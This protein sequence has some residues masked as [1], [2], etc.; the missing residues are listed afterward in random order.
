MITFNDLKEKYGNR[1]YLLLTVAIVTTSFTM[2]T[3]ATII[4]VAVPS[5]MGTFG[6]GQDKA[7]LMATSFYVAMTASQLSCAFLIKVFGH[8]HIFTISIIVFSISCFVGALSELFYVL[9]FA[10]VVQGI[11][12][13]ILMSQTMVA[14]MQAFPLN[15]RGL[16]LT[17]FTCGTVA[18]FGAGPSLGGLIIDYVNWRS[19]FL[20]PLPLILFALIVGAFVMHT[21]KNKGTI[22][23]DWS[24][25]VCLV[26]ALYSFMTVF[27]EG[28]RQGWTSNFIV[29]FLIV[30]LC[31]SIIFIVMQMYKNDRLMDFTIFAY[32]NFLWATIVVFLTSLGNFGL[33]YAI[34]VFSQLVLGLSPLDAGI[35]MLPASIIAVLFL[36]VMGKFSD[37]LPA[38]YGSYVG[39]ILF[40]CGSFPL[41][42]SDTN[43]PFFLM[44]I[45]AIVSRLGMGINNPY[46]SKAALMKLPED[47]IV[48]ATSIL[49]FFRLLGSSIGTS[50]WVVF[51]EI[52]TKFHGENIS[53]TQTNSNHTTSELIYN[54]GAI[55]RGAGI[56]ENFLMPLSLKFLDKI[57]YSQALTFGFQDGFLILS[58]VFLIALIP[59]Y[60]LKK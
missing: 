26:I 28:Q 16:S 52:R 7:Q 27:A 46:A 47:K 5:I 39:L 49:N 25:L 12:A 33:I 4:T 56:S 51:L 6:V 11:T 10:R 48:E 34:P 38:K 19:V 57:L 59:A 32:P 58:I 54:L 30:G 2:V 44:V 60:L 17:L 1:F 45:L 53:F 43:T 20:I 13:G 40:F 8:R 9:V 23:F 3:Y 14:I 42:F 18:G 29:N 15:R 50:A 21:K 55:L 31:F 24:G 22:K 36:P 41:V 37:T 35:I